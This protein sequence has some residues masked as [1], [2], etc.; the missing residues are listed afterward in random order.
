MT[1]ALDAA[2]DEL[3]CL[4]V[5]IEEQLVRRYNVTAEIDIGETVLGYGKVR[6]SFCLYVYDKLNERMLLTGASRATRTRACGHLTELLFAL[7]AA[8]SEHLD[9]VRDAIAKAS[10]VLAALRNLNSD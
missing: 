10:K 5:R 8:G 4:I 6:Q 9:E 1:N 3:N 2:T 7:D